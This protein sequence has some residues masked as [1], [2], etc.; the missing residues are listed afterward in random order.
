R[1]ETEIKHGRV[2]MFATMGYIVPEY[3][4]FDGYL[5]PSMDLKFADVPNG[6]KA[7]SVVPKEGWAQMLAFAGF[8]ELVVNKKSSEPGNYGKGN[9]GLGNVGFGNSI[10][11]PAKRNRQLSAELA[12][13]RLAMMA[14]MG[15]LLD[16][17]LAH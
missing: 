3:Y 6:L 11:D 13:G 2:A 17:L 14:I 4:K 10:Q 15:M 16:A 12:N 5:S 1:R 9:F 7:L 8:L